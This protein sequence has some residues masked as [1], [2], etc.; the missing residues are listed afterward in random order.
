METTIIREK[1]TRLGYIDLLGIISAFAV[2]VL[3]VNEVIHKFSYDSY[4]FSANIIECLMYFA[5]PVFLFISSGTLLDYRDRYSTKEFFKRRIHKTVIPFIF[6]SLCAM[7]AQIV[8]GGYS[9]TSNIT[10]WYIIDGIINFKF[11]SIYSF[12][13]YLFGIYFA[14][15]VLSNLKDKITI[16]KYMA[17]VGLLINCIVPLVCD[18]AGVEYYFTTFE[19]CF[20]Y[21]I[22]IPLGY[23]LV[24]LEFIQKQRILIY[25]LGLMGLLLHTVGT[26]AFS[27]RDGKINEVFK[28]YTKLPGIL[29]SIAVFVFIRYAYPHIVKR[30]K[31]LPDVLRKISLYTFGIYLVHIY[32]IRAIKI[33]FEPDIYSLGYRIVVPFIVFPISILVVWVIRKIPKIGKIILPS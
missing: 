11:L 16:F 32:I 10:P 25:V 3:H 28:G 33:V 21:T 12:F 15:P 8:L 27:L 17:T 1:E 22:Y 13:G 19:L 14:I 5:V 2:V 4:W 6:W 31:K 9:R 20:G 7:A 18:L 26:Y 30:F 24:N 29:Y 23:L